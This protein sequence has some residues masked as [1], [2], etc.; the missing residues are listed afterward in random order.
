MGLEDFTNIGG[1]FE[2]SMV[3]V[4]LNSALVGKMQLNGC[5]KKSKGEGGDDNQD[6]N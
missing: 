3:L 4:G 2:S 6:Y 5:T 1:G